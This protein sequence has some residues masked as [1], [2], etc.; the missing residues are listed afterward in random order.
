MIKAA[1]TILLL[2]SVTAV[3]AQVN[4]ASAQV[5]TGDSGTVANSNFG[6]IR[7]LHAPNIAGFPANAPLWYQWKASHSGVV[8]LDTV[9]S[10]AY[11]DLVLTN[12]YSNIVTQVTI[13]GSGTT[14]NYIITIYTNIINSTNILNIDTVLGVY[15]GTTPQFLNQVAANDDIFPVNSTLGVSGALIS[16]LDDDFNEGIARIFTGVDGNETGEVLPGEF[17]FIPPYYGPSHLKFNAVGGQTYYFAVDTK[18]GTTGG[19]VFNWAYKSSGVFRFASEDQDWVTG[20]PLYQTA[21]TESQTPVG[22]GNV[23]VD[24]VV[25]TYYTYNAP[26]VLVTVTRAAGSVGRAVVNYQTIDGTSLPGI[27]FGTQPGLAGFDYVNTGGQLVFDDFEMS[28]TILVPIIYRGDVA[29]DQS[30]RVFGIQLTSAGLDLDEDSSSVSEPRLDPA[31]SIAVI[32]ILNSDGDAYGPDMVPLSLTNATSTDTNIFT[33]NVKALAPTNNIFNFEKTAFRVPADV[34]DPALGSFGYANATLYVERFGTNGSSETINYK[35]DAETLDNGT[36]NEYLNEFPLQP[37]S[38][39]AVPLPANQNTTDRNYATSN[40]DRITTNYDFDVVDGTLSFPAEPALGSDEQAIHIKIPLSMATKFNKDFRISLYRVVKNAPLLTGMNAQAT[41]TVLFNDENPPAGS[42]DELYNADLNGDLALLPTQVPSTTPG[43]DSNPG[44]GSPGNPG[45]VY[46]IAVL[47]NDEALIGGAFSS[48]NGGNGASQNNIALINTNGQ[49]DTSFN[50]SSGFNG[51]VNAVALAGSQYLIGGAFSSY[52]NNINSPGGI[53]R[54][55][56]NGSLDTTFNTHGAGTTNLVRAVLVETNGEILIGGD[57]TSYDG[58]PCDYLALLTTNGLFD[59][60]FNATAIQGPVYSLAQAPTLLLVTNLSVNNNGAEN[61]QPLVITPFSSGTLTVNYNMAVG[62]SDLRVFYGNTNVNANTGVAIFDTGFTNGARTI[63]VPF[64]PTT[65][66]ANGSLLSANFLTIV[67]N[68]SNVTYNTVWNYKATVTVS[69]SSD[70]ILVGGNF[71]VAGQGYRDLARLN[72]N[73]SLDT[74]FNP[75]TGADGIVHTMAWQ[76]DNKVIIGGEFTHVDGISDNYLA[77]LDADGTLDTTNFFIGSGA[78]NNVYS[79]NLNLDNTFYV[80]GAFS[81][82]NGTHRNGFARMYSNGSVDTT[83]MDTA[84]NQ[85]AGLKKILSYD[86]PSVFASMVQN[87][88]GILIGGSFLQV[89]GGQADPNVANT[90]DDELFYTESFGDPNEWVEPKTRDGF[91]NRTGFARLIGGSTAGPGNISLSQASYSQTKSQTS[92]TVSL[93]RTNGTLGQASANFFVQ[94]GGALPGQDYFYQANEPL[95]WITWR[96]SNLP[97]RMREDGLW[98]ISGNGFLKD[99]LNQSLSASDAAINVLPLVNVTMI[100]NQ[101][102]P[103]NQS[104]VFQL[105]NPSMADNFYLGSE[106]IP[107]GTAL[108]ISS[109]QFTLI[110]DTTYPGQFGFSSTNFVATNTTTPITLVR[111]G[112]TFGTV[113]LIYSTANGTATSGKDYTAIV[114]GATTFN[115]GIQN[116]NFNV[117]ILNNNVITNVEKTFNIKITQLQLTPNATPGIV[118]TVVRIINPNSAGFLSLSANTNIG[119]LSS[120]VL[121]FTVNRNSGSLGTVTVLYSTTNNTAYSGTNYVGVTNAMLQWTSGDVSPRTVS[122]PLINQGLV[123]TGNLLFGVALTN[124]T[125]NTTN[126]PALMGIIPSAVMVITNDNNA[127]TLQFAS[128]AYSVNESGGYVTLNVVRLGGVIGTATVNFTTVDGTAIANTTHGAVTNY[129]ATNGILT[130]AANQTTASIQVPILNDGIAD[131]ANF[132]FTVSLSHAINGTLGSPAVAQVNISDAQTYNQPPGSPDTSFN[133]PGMNG[134]VFSLAL[135][136]NSQILAA[137][138]F[139]AVGSTP[140]GYLARLNSDGTLDTGFLT[141]AIGSGL[142]GAFGPVN[143]VICQSDGRIVVGG[144][145]STIDDINRN[146]IARLLSNGSLDTSFNPGPGAN[147]PVNA[148][149]ETFINGVRRIYVGGSFTA[150]AGS[151][152]AG[153]A[154]I[155]A[156]TSDNVNEGLVDGAFNIGSGLDGQVYAIAVYPTNSIYAGKVLVGGSFQHYNGISVT[157]VVRI[158]VDGTLDT[159]FNSGI[160]VGPNGIVQ[161][162]AI[163]LDGNILLG[164]NFTSFNNTNANYIV[165][166]LPNGTMDSSFVGSANQSVQGITLQ[167][168]N[169][170]LLVGQFSSADGILRNGVA[171]LLPTGVTDPTINFGS[172]AN[173][174]V[175]TLVLQPANNTIIIGGTFSEYDGLPYNNITR[176]FGGSETGSGQFQFT[177]ANYFVHESGNFAVITVQRTGGTSGTNADGTGNDLVD[178]YT[179]NLPNLF[180]ATNGINYQATNEIVTFPPGAVFESVIVPV[181]D[182]GPIETSNLVV[183]LALSGAPLGTVPTATLSIINDDNGVSFT[184]PPF[185]TVQKDAF[186]GIATIDIIRQGGTNDTSTVDFSTITNG[187]AIIG[188]DYTPTN[189]VITFAP[190]VSDVQVQIAITNNNLVEGNRTVDLVLSNATAPTSL[191]F[192]SNA[193]LTIIDTTPSPGYLAFSTNSFVANKTDTNAY[194]TIIRTNGTTGPVSAFVNVT[195]GSAVPTVNYVAPVVNPVPVSFSGGQNSDTI[196]VQLIPNNLVQGTV[197][198]SVTLTNVSGGATLAAPTNATV[199]IVNNVNTGVEFAFG[200]NIVSETN[201]TAVV[202]VE[203]EGFPSNSFSVNYATTDG[204]AKAGVNYQSSVGT[205][206][207]ATNSLFLPISVQLINQQLTTNLT[208]GITLSSPVNAQVLAPSN[209]LMIL[210][211][212]RAGL[213]FTNSAISVFKNAGVISIPVV[214]NNPGLEP[215]VVNSNVIP[216]TVSYFTANG[217]ATAGQDYIAENGTLIFTNGIG[218]NYIF[219][220]VINNSLITGNRTFT[221]SLTNAMANGEINAP[222]NQVVTIVDSNSGL[223]FNQPT[224]TAIRSGGTVLITVVRTD[225]TNVVSTVNFATANGTAMTN[226][227]Y[228]PTNGILT[229]TNGLTTN[230]FAVTLISSTTVQPDKTVLLQLTSPTNGMLISPSAATLTIHDTSGSLVVPAGST[231][232]PGGN[233]NN[234]GLIDPGETVTLYFAFRAEGGNTITNLYAT[235]LPVSGVTAPTTPAPN[236]T[237]TQVYSNLFVGGPSESQP[238]TF[239]ASGTNGQQ[240][241]ATFSLLE[242]FGGVTNNLGTNIFTYS[243]GT[244]TMSFTNTNAIVILPATINSSQAGA[245]A[246]YPSIISI[247][248]IVGTVFNTIITLTNLTHTSEYNVNAMLVSPSASDTLFLSHAGTPAIGVSGVTLTFS[249]TATN[250]LP[251]FNNQAFTNGV[252]KPAANG[253]TPA[254]P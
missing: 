19:L 128:P 223:S 141:G 74:T 242:K 1:L 25:N 114:N 142:D 100:R 71:S 227:D 78:D 64:A 125:L 252:Y 118:N 123:G 174:D 56:P 151:A 243:L 51:A 171:R 240:I 179:T 205:L 178:F 244:W 106:E 5:L 232:A 210:Q 107:I 66:T 247:S 148:L 23:D 219:V 225:N 239:T 91:R 203:R 246:P 221:V 215:V 188:T 191:L 85:F 58:I 4:F 135:Q 183:G 159:N 129:I 10:I 180:N 27:S 79:I 6:V 231:F 156:D 68:Q 24:S 170:I 81:T 199:S 230:T 172:G 154:R 163:Q 197:T 37:G 211:G 104:A 36:I 87:N 102:N 184:T 22:S 137:G 153:I 173:G 83:F 94:P 111:T 50:M 34:A 47:T 103:G 116:T 250:T 208:F 132:F 3:K 182:D 254:F 13:T 70:N 120:G 52:Q 38:D 2:L 84:Y 229:F 41:V 44:V 127:G 204:S 207:F 28:K 224:Y 169:R 48:Y 15:Q 90:M 59:T 192:P 213:F 72:A 93:V 237:A 98:G 61:D 9:G 251:S 95:Y 46:S 235:L 92:L 248:N 187:T 218:T 119:Y 147:G 134:S 249:D 144:A 194:I 88:G 96:Y 43:D 245:A 86:T 253:A 29:L 89:G 200:T 117:T 177:S 39:Y 149:A 63:V 31:S 113:R 53:V 45:Q 30:N 97:S 233:P 214:C 216:L 209:T 12:V 105:A 217:T 57:F 77:R 190:G 109:A 11:T 166:L 108:G 206:T 189:E 160:G 33:F 42:V 21:E 212:G 161:A 73:G 124:P 32:K 186:S 82:M 152:S 138:N 40:Y 60:N 168:D 80:G 146:D 122:I 75:P 241:A 26:G 69:Q 140:E 55:N 143:S 65:A 238:Y 155:D 165:R 202:L 176:I 18:A 145:F 101:Q 54:V 228:F 131:P 99:A 158:N 130:F 76:F 121:N 136:P 157:N 234:D 7:D 175:D 193:V 110:D 196:A 35:V 67:M 195:P 226:V 201:G 126:D 150:I 17:E 164:G 167:P 139:T 20:L 115:T 198:F 49:L 222:S 14:T 162:I 181:F 16:P 8:E 112:G 220:P 133:T 236:G 185:Y 62:A